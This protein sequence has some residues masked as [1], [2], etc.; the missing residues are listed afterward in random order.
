MEAKDSSR[1]TAIHVAVLYNKYEIVDFDVESRGG[2][3]DSRR[4]GMDSIA[5]CS[6]GEL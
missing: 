3:G 4:T 2:P 1:R 6:L 5:Y